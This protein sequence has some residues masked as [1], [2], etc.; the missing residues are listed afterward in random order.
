MLVSKTS[1]ST[2]SRPNADSPQISIS[3][4][5][6]PA[7]DKIPSISGGIQSARLPSMIRS[8]PVGYFGGDA[9]ATGNASCRVSP[10]IYYGPKPPGLFGAVV[11]SNRGK[12][13][14][15]MMMD[16]S[17]AFDNLVFPLLCG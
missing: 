7:H 8:G 1:P 12:Q 16:Q 2:H 11:F 9:L 17:T 13:S 6:L 5:A 4:S 14:K 10:G 3:K 15:R